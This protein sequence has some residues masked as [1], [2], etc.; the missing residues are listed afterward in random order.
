MVLVV[1]LVAHRVGLPQQLR[2]R[3]R[4]RASH[5]E[6]GQGRGHPARGA[7]L[8]RLAVQQAR[9]LQLQ[10]GG[11]RGVCVCAWCVCVCVRVCVCVCVRVC[12]CVCLYACVCALPCTLCM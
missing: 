1:L 6:G 11:L 9:V 4:M 7:H 5:E 12:V 10:R 2:V 8:R 3:V